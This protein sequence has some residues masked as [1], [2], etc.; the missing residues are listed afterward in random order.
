MMISWFA[1]RCRADFEAHQ[2]LKT[3]LFLLECAIRAGSSSSI[4]DAGR[5]SS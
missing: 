1:I 3:A 4:L 5:S 2:A